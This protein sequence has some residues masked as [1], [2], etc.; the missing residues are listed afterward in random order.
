[1]K[2]GQSEQHRNLAANKMDIAGNVKLCLC[3]VTKQKR[4]AKIYAL[5]CTL[6]LFSLLCVVR[7]D[8]RWENSKTNPSDAQSNCPHCQSPS[9]RYDTKIATIE[10]IKGKLLNAMQLNVTDIPKSPKRIYP[11]LSHFLGISDQNQ[12]DVPIHLRH[13]GNAGYDDSE[14]E[15]RI[16]L[17]SEMFQGE[18]CKFFLFTLNI[19]LVL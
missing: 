2:I 9:A 13:T 18:I 5:M 12:I 3:S 14:E 17:Q 6:V 7:G 10:Y 4:N 16:K 15:E 19:N 8:A 11:P 1:M